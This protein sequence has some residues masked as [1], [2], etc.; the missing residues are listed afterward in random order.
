MDTSRSFSALR[1]A[2]LRG[3]A[4]GAL[5]VAAASSPA[6][7]DLA[8]VPLFSTTS[9]VPGNLILALSVEWPTA[10]TPAYTSS[11]AYVS[12]QEFLGYFDPNKCYRYVYDATTPA[13]SYFT[14]VSTTANR[15]CATT[16]GSP[17]WSGNYLNWSSMQ[18][19]DAFRWVL[20]GGY[21]SVDT[22]ASTVLTKTN[23]LQDSGVMPHKR[24]SSGVSTATPFTWSTI[25]SRVR[26]LRTQMFVTNAAPFDC[27]G[28]TNSSGAVSFSCNTGGNALACTGNSCNVS[29]GTAGNLV[30]GRSGN[31]TNYTYACNVQDSG[32]TVLTRLSGTA[33]GTNTA[34]LR[35][36]AGTGT[37][38]VVD[39]NNQTSVEGTALPGVTYRLYINV[40][41]CDASVGLESNCVRYGNNYKPE[42]LMQQY[43]TKLRYSAFGYLNISGTADNGGTTQRDGGVMRARMKYIG[44]QVTV[45]GKASTANTYAEWDAN[46]GIMAT[47]PDAVDATATVAAAAALGWTVTVPN[48]GVMNYLNKFGYASNN[49]KSN[50]PVSE[51]YYAALRY[52]RNLGD[53]ASYSSIAN[54]G[55]AATAQA[56][57][58]SFPVIT[59]DSVWKKSNSTTDAHFGS[60]ILYTCQKNFVLGIGDVYTWRD[61]NLQGSTLRAASTWE[62]TLPTEVNADTEINVA[63]ATDMVGRLEGLTGST[64]LGSLYSN[65]SNTSCAAGGQCNSYYVAGLAYHAHTND[66]RSDMA[67]SQTV[68]TYWMDVLEGQVYRHKNQYWLAAK[69]GGFDVPN[70]FQPYAT[71]N[72][73][74]T[75]AQTTWATTGDTLPIGQGALTFSTDVAGS[76]TDPRPDNY[77]PG[78]RPDVMRAGLTAAFAKIASELESATS[79][80]FSTTSANVESGTASYSADYDPKNWTGNV[81]AS[82]ITYDAQGKPTLTK[83]WDA[84]NVL[85]TAVANNRKIVTCCTGGGTA[86]P[87]RSADLG[88]GGLSSRTY[89]ASFTNVPN[90]PAANQSLANYVQYL[91]GDRAQERVNGGAYRTRAYRL[92]DIVGAKVN[93]VGPPNDRYYDATNPGYSSFKRT[94]ANRKTVVYVGAN[95]GMMHAFDGTLPTDANNDGV[96][97]PCSTCGSE[98][99]AYVPSF[100]YGDAATASTNGLAALGNPTTFSH[101]FL[102]DG[103]P[104]HFDIDFRRTVGSTAVAPDW[105]TIVI[106]GLGKGGKGYYAIDVTDPTSWTNET[107]VAGKVLW[108]FTDPRMG[109]SYGSPIVVKTAKYGWTVIFTSGYNNADG[110]GYFFFVNPRTGALLET[111]ATTEGGTL[112]PLNM[113]H[114]TAFVPDYT[115]FTA[116]AVYAGDLQGNVWR[117]D[118]TQTGAYAAPTKIATLSRGGIAQPVTTRPL[119]EIEANTNRR[120]VFV[121]T[122]RLLADSD[123]TSNAPQSFYAIV[124]GLGTPGLF[125]TPASL[126]TGKMFPLSRADL[127]ANTSLLTGIGATPTSGLGWYHDLPVDNTSNIGWRVTVTPTANAG[128]LAFA[129]NLPSGDACNP[130]GVGRIYGVSFAEGKTV[131]ETSDNDT[132]PISFQNVGQ[133]ITDLAFQRVNGRLRLIAGDA[134]GTVGKVPAALSNSAGT[135]RINW[136]SV[137]AT[138]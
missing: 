42:G 5:A 92:G 11:T 38:A 135:R 96:D 82:R 48:S 25:D 69:Y 20:T 93:P 32:G 119:V 47:N 24:A 22:T 107:A 64:P 120:Y 102:V 56:W 74:T 104:L 26:A 29:L 121:G 133:V 98:L 75:L 4:G 79:T 63:A 45:P 78:N 58:D 118:L 122:G 54:A 134:S 137:P 128:V 2:L 46:T 10:T 61:S 97:D 57:I 117:V 85:E 132:T 95:D 90:V 138:E 123:I 81:T 125:F 71:T 87:F 114:A 110:R 37:G 28:V 68:N 62:P 129:A 103:R 91:R 131:L 99:F 105:R 84:R 27:T 52:F 77:F 40:R 60:P 35:V 101:R 49:Y 88:A 33:S 115:D 80:A 127:N 59:S 16:S 109:F 76:T 53:V 124:D 18:T 136:R 67:G 89:V 41:V 116:D 17:R 36:N 73:P 1:L 113:A 21:R 86:L 30:C 14:P 72:G 50:D 34:T 100:V 112:T 130:S 3:L 111:V 51:L 6:Q 55:N 39:Y 108:E 7:I 12:T 44:P 19:L 94:Y 83:K 31:A 66:L 65:T 23:A 15:T 9:A 106:G 8:D 70:S 126:P 13:N 43:A